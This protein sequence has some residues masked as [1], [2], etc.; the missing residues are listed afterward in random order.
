MK[1]VLSVKAAE[2]KG[3]MNLINKKNALKRRIS[4]AQAY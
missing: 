4:E 3:D 1:F 2:R